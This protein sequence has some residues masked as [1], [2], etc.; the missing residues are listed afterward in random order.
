LREQ[1]HILRD[2]GAIV[3]TV[4]FLNYGSKLLQ[5]LAETVLPV[6][7]RFTDDLAQ[8]V[9]AGLLTS[10]AGHATIDR[11]RAFRGWNEAEAKETLRS[12]LKDFAADLKDVVTTDLFAKIRKPVEA[13]TPWSSAS[14]ETMSRVREG[15]ATALDDTAAVMD[16][17]VRR[18]VVVAGQ[19]VA[20]AGKA[21]GRFVG[22]VTVGTGR[23]VWRGTKASADLTRRATVGAVKGT[24][25]G[26][27]A[28]AELPVRLFRR[29]K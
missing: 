15:L 16:T 24:G 5:N 20:A 6:L 7:G 3:A 4:N 18:P 2:V 19:G 9:G 22:S 10:V 25:K 13:Q 21:S 26:L 29:K 12:K 8:G 28:V 27:K 1:L 11:C 17:F 14:P 23:A